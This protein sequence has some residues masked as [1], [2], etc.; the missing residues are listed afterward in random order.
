M[1]TG[2]CARP[3]RDAHRTPE[4]D[5]LLEWLAE[6]IR[7]T[8][9]SLLDEWEAL[10]DPDRAGARPPPPPTS[11]RPISRQDRAFRVM[12]RNAMWRRVDL[13][14]R[15]DLDGLMALERAAADRTDPPREVVMTRS[16]WDDAIEDYYA[17]HDTVLHRRR[18][19][20]ARPAA[21]R[22]GHR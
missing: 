19:P 9:S 6:T 17:Q 10:T 3:C 15:D 8:D 11:P 7:Q 16:T 14:A 5:D 20:R 22:G 2:P 12:V 21:H 1:P 13:V 18:R 4:L